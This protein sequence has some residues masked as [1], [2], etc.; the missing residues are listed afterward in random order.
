MSC[1]RLEEWNAFPLVAWVQN[2]E[3]DSRGLSWTRIVHNSLAHKQASDTQCLSE[4]SMATEPTIVA[5]RKS[6]CRSSN[7]WKSLC[8]DGGYP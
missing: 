6:L 2:D 8:A 1:V 7:Y 3:Q 5:H 4:A